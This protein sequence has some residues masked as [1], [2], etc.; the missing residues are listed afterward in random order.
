MLAIGL[1]HLFGLLYVELKKLDKQLLALCLFSL[2]Y[3][4]QI[5]VLEKEVTQVVCS[6][7]YILTHNNVRLIVAGLY[8]RTN[9]R[10]YA[11]AVAITKHAYN[12]GRKILF[13]EYACTERIVYIVVYVCNSIG[14]LNNNAL[15]SGLC[16]RS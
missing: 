3:G 2:S 1:G 5:Y 11:L 10:V 13:L 16:L 7:A 14:I 4:I 12:V 15:K 8:D 9:H 6:L